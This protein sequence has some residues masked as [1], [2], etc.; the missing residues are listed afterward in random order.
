MKQMTCGALLLSTLLLG[1]CG[2]SAS[3]PLAAPPPRVG[4]AAATPKA[5]C[6]PDSR[7]EL[8]LQGRIS[9]AEHQSGRAAE[10]YTCNMEV[11]GSYTTATAFGTVGGFK[12]ERYTDSTGRTCAYYDTTLTYPTNLG[13]GEAGVNVLDMSDPTNPVLTKRLVTPAMLTPHESLIANQ[14]SG[15][16]AAVTGNAPR[17]TPDLW[18]CMTSRP[19]AAT[20]C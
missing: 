17:S 11:V 9:R 13:T 18:M 16:L 19:T 6:G 8:G 10:G 14:A 12:V 15:V 4:E 7:P 20:R 2:N 5:L 3:E 1:A